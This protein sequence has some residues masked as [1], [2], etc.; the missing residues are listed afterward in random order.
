[1]HGILSANMVTLMK[2]IEKCN[3]KQPNRMHAY[4]WSKGF[5]T[6]AYQEVLTYVATY[7]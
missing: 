4:A 7:H 1:M 5:L 2:D 3:T 6:H